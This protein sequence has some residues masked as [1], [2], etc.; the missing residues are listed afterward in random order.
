METHQPKTSDPKSSPPAPEGKAELRQDGD[1]TCTCGGILRLA[2]LQVMHS[3]PKCEA[4]KS[5]PW[6]ALIV[7]EITKMHL[8]Q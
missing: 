3:L 5:L 8:R 7:A 1:G 2:G 4:I 6:D